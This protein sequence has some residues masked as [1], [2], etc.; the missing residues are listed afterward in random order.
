MGGLLKQAMP[1]K[2]APRKET[3]EQQL[4]FHRVTIVRVSLVSSMLVELPSLTSVDPE[5]T[6][7]RSHRTA[8]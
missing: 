3:L 7:S 4:P 8:A 1:L 5:E 6:N 2:M